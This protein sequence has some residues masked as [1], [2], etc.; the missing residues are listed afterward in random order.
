VEGRGAE[1]IAEAAGYPDDTAAIV[2]GF[3]TQRER[4]REEY[5]RRR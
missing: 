5:L 1:L 2:A 4:E 3:Q